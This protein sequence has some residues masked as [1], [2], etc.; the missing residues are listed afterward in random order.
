MIE[1]SIKWLA[2][3][4]VVVSVVAS[5]TPVPATQAKDRGGRWGAGFELGLWKRTGGERD[6]SNVDGFGSV[7]LNRGLSEDWN[8]QVSLRYGHT[9]AGVGLRGDS[10]GWSTDS[11]A[12]IYTTTW[13]PSVRIQRRFALGRNVTPYAG[14]GLGLMSWKVV[15]WFGR[16]DEVGFFPGGDP[17]TGYDTSG[18]ERE[19]KRTE[20]AVTG[21]LGLEYAL[22]DQWAL[23]GG[24]RLHWTPSN[25]QDNVGLSSRWGP[26][27]VDANPTAVDFFLGA[28]L[29]FG[30]DDDRDDD[31]IPNSE[32]GCP[33]A[34]EDVDGYR[35]GDGC[36]DPDNDADGVADL[37]DRCPDAAEDLDGYEDGDGCPDPDND[38]DGIV[39][40]EDGCPEE[41]EDLDGH[42]DD[43]GC[44]D[45]DDDGD[46]VADAEDHC[47]G[48]PPGAEVDADGCEVA[49]AVPSAAAAATTALLLPAPGQTVTLEL[50]AFAPGSAQLLPGSEEYLDDWA[51]LLAADPDI[52]VEVRGHTDSVGS[53]ELNRELSQRRASHVRDELIRRG[54]APNQATAVGYGEDK[55]VAP[56]TTA[57]GRATNRRVELHRV[58]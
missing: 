44:P 52:R 23:V 36:P 6:Y 47:P 30:G 5:A 15:D 58:R 49:V 4:A 12:A 22:G 14:A 18:K 1:R 32:D 25:Q 35:D 33:D 43:D 16:E 40:A 41:A 38:G 51:A 3:L 48:T 17:V 28:T 10:A 56:N 55:P 54:A 26:D 45:T 39:D 19:L 42:E 53:A 46:G 13:Q 8:L 21:E 34:A 24:V 57:R 31:G 9:R 7:L 2:T 27:H 20:A 11:G 37:H 50:S 29:W